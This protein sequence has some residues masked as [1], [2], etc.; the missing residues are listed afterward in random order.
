[1]IL[2]KVGGS[3][4]INWEGIISDIKDLDEEVIIVHGASKIRDELAKKLNFPTKTI[5]SPS[6]IESVYTDKKAM[7]V[8]L[9]S[10][11]GL[12]NKRIVERFQGADLDVVG[13]TG[14]DAKIWVGKRKKKILSK[15]KDKVKVI[16]DSFTGRVEEINS[17]FLV[18]LIE[19]G[20]I[21]IISPPAISYEG[22][23][24]NVDNDLAIATM[25]KEMNIEKII[26]LF[27]AGGLRKN[28]DDPDSLVNRIKREEIDDYLGYAKGTMQK[29]VIGAKKALKGGVKEI[30]WGG[31][32][33]ERPVKEALEG[34][35]TVIKN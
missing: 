24:I 14:A 25:A 16:G 10:Y 23:L 5:T 34:K 31:V 12:V 26:V 15:E 17:D 7:D 13:L 8:F 9:M 27:G 32:D 1:M 33:G 28:P 2:I 35:G 6:G 20:I 18:E 19:E 29:K 4:N 22:D 11:A 30:Y 3:K 21:P